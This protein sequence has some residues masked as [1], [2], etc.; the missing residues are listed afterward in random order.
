MGKLPLHGPMDFIA[1]LWRMFPTSG[2]LLTE[3]LRCVECPKLC[4]G[5]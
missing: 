5:I 1:R 3:I 4:A 2:R